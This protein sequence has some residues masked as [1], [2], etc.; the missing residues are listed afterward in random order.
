MGGGGDIFF[1]VQRSSIRVQCSS[2]G[3]SVAQKGAT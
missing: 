1:R 2:V 3:C